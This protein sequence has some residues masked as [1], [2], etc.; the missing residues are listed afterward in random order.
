MHIGLI[1]GIGPAATE[2]YYRHLVRRHEAEDR[3]MELTIVHAHVHTLAANAIAGRAEAQ[4][5][6]YAVLTA[7]L[8]GAG[9][10]AV[11]ITSIGG[12]FCFD[13]FEPV[14]PLPVL[15]VAP[16]IAAGLRARGVSRIGL[17]GTA[18]AM[19]SGI[20]GALSDIGT[21]IPEGDDLQTTND[22]YIALARAGAVSEEGR[23][24]LFRI[25]RDLV[26]RQGAEAVLLAGTDLFVAFD[27]RD[28]G[29]PTIDGALLHVDAIARAS[30][31]GLA[32][33]PG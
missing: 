17:I 22:V 16:A 1:G 15:N 4:A 33:Y 10:E 6:E 9:A 18:V 30:M 24:T 11:A 8:K 23:A 32:A 31:F 28:P 27:G 14:S 26:E 7:R 3:P 19:T 12:H 21:V 2:F 25:G 20:Y 5:G 29:Y 13:E